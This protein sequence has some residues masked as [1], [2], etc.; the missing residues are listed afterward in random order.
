MRSIVPAAGNLLIGT[1]KGTAI[2]SVIAVDE[3]LY[4]AQFIYNRTFEVV[5]LL[6]VAT[7][8]YMF[9]TAVLSILQY[10]VERYYGR[11]ATRSA[12]VS[13]WQQVRRALLR[14]RGAVITPKRGR[15]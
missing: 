15:E 5:P 9:M 7:L 3:L 2:V 11:G 4:A 6:V 13:P 8:W 10:F 1:L 14:T 12:V